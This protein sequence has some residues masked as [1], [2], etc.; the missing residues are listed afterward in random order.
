M[1]INNVN[2]WLAALGEP[3]IETIDPVAQYGHEVARLVHEFV[4]EGELGTHN[5]D[6]VDA[7]VQQADGDLDAL[8]ELFEKDIMTRNAILSDHLA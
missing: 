7:L 6:E 3:P 4:G 8:R 5:V 2:S 1:G